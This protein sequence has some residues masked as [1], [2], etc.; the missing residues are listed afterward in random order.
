MNSKKVEIIAKHD[1]VREYRII[2]FCG[3]F[4]TPSSPVEH[5]R[6]GAN[7]QKKQTTV[8][9]TFKKYGVPVLDLLWCYSIIERELK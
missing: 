8:C 9:W 4:N 3:T 1:N 6:Q 2:Y 7:F 5:E